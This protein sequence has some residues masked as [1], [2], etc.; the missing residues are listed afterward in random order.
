MY[1][2]GS[3][4]RDWTHVVD[5]VDCIY[6]VLVTPNIEGEVF[7]ICSGTGRKILNIASNLIKLCGKE[8]LKPVHD[9]TKVEEI[10]RSVGDPSKAHKIL[11]WKPKINFDK[12]LRGAIEFY[13]IQR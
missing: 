13:S 12:G 1:G 4:I 6:R 7:N 11:G 3:Q 2:G 9:Y 8:N 5:L 10:K